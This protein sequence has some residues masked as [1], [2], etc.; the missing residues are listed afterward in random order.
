MDSMCTCVKCQSVVPSVRAVEIDGTV[1]CKTCLM[2]FAHQKK[3]PD[4]PHR[5]NIVLLFFMSC[6]PGANYMYMGLMKYG[7]FMMSL[8]FG[9]IYLIN[10]FGHYYFSVALPILIF[11]SFF[12]GL[13][14]RRAINAGVPVADE[15]PDI[16]GN[17]YK[18]RST[19]LVLGILL[20]IL[21]LANHGG[22][23]LLLIALALAFFLIVGHRKKKS[24]E[25]IGS[26]IDLT[27]ENQ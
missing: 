21:S 11:Y 26:M 10:A 15:L 24:E 8:F 7:L 17:L 2:Q 25:E 23:I 13:S 12:D 6:L 3:A 22:N 18:H 16:L 5:V 14:K 1:F 27:K 20:F 19:V 9:S 4:K